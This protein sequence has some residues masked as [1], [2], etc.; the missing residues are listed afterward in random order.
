M[1]ARFKTALCAAALAVLAGPALA[2][3]ITGNIQFTGSSQPLG[4]VDFVNTGTVEILDVEVESADGDFAAAGIVDGD[5]AIFND[6]FYRQDPFVPFT[7]W[8]VGGFS[9]ELETVTILTAQPQVL[10]LSG[11]GTVSAAGAG[12]DDT[13]GDWL[14]TSQGPGTSFSF[15]SGTDSTANPVPVPATVLFLITGL[16]ATIGLAARRPRAA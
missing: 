2:A 15:S 13:P 10:V 6:I 14:F 16:L 9:F 11:S 12:F 8:N 1:I 7:L 3:P 5:P 4:A